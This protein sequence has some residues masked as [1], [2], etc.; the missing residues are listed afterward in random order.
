MNTIFIKL[1][2]FLVALLL[3]QNVNV[4]VAFSQS[5]T[6]VE[7]DHIYGESNSFLEYEKIV[8]QIENFLTTRPDQYEWQWRLART[9]Y[10][11]AKI[12]PKNN[13]HHFELCIS[14]SSKA[15]DLQPDSAISYFYRGLCRGKQGERDCRGLRPH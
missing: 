10:A 2:G 6:L 8:T 13:M 4:T 14:Y 12:L 1:R 15:I 5:P 11:I 9:H 7:I 3:T